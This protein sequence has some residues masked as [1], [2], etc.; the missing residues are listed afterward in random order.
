[1]SLVLIRYVLTAAVRDKVFLAFLIM[2]AVGASLSLFFASSAVIE[3]DQFAIIYMGGGLRIISALGLVLFVVF[4]MR[5]SFDTRDVEFLLTRP[6]PRPV[7]LL[8][9]AAAF[10]IIAVVTGLAVAGTIAVWARNLPD[11]SGLPLWTLGLC[12]EL[13]IVA[14]VALFFSMVLSSPVSG[15]LACLGFYVLARLMG[16]LLLITKIG[17][18]EM[19]VVHVFQLIMRFLSI[20]IPRFDLLL[21]SNW[22]IYGVSHGSVGYGFLLGQGVVFLSM[23]LLAALFDLQKRQF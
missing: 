6:L 19:P 17:I 20:F 4:H 16:Q 13:V 12:L 9:H 1:M 21:Q 22:L 10:S 23:V 7:F 15:G 11:L 18:S 8:S 5:R 14:N 2:L 3:K